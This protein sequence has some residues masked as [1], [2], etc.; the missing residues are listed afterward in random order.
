MLAP[1]WQARCQ[2]S[3]AFD[4]DF[5]R[6][7]VVLRAVE[8]ARCLCTPGALGFEWAGDRA[9]TL[10]KSLDE[11]E[12]H[13]ILGPVLGWVVPEKEQ[14]VGKRKAPRRERC[15]YRPPDALRRRP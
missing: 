5:K 13:A 4:T 8:F 7:R 11:R 14:R 1:T 9:N 10:T 6:A 15:A 2:L 3:P 12:L